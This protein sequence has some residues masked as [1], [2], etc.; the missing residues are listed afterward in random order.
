[1]SPNSIHLHRSIVYVYVVVVVAYLE[2]KWSNSQAKQWRTFV[3][4]ICD[5]LLLVN[6][7]VLKTKI[8]CSLNILVQN[9]LLLL[10]SDY[11]I[12]TFRVIAHPSLH[13]LIARA[14]SFRGRNAQV[15]N[16]HAA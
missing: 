3:L 13:A 5:M 16:V 12:T 7:H 6:G 9:I 2:N 1:M 14:L 4:C 11:V 15:P 10:T 8:P